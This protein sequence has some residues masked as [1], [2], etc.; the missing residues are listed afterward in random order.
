MDD[1]IAWYDVQDTLLGRNSTTRDVKKAIKLA[2]QCK[3]ENAVWMTS[4]FAHSEIRTV[5]DVIRVFVAEQSPKAKCF[6]AMLSKPVDLQLLRE[7]ASEG[8]PFAMT[9]LG[10]IDSDFGLV[11]VFPKN[12]IKKKNLN[13]FPGLQKGADAGDREG[14]S[15]LAQFLESGLGCDKDEEKA[16]YW[17]K[18]SAELGDG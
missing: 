10:R 7:A 11:K 3:H 9:V 16:K 8:V 4:L 5:D 2:S 1:E 17:G 12:K 15:L 18:K 13:D 6:A 14:M